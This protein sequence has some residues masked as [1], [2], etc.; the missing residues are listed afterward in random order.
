M[1]LKLSD[2][3]TE[4]LRSKIID[5]LLAVAPDIEDGKIDD[6]SP[7]QEIYGLDSAD[8][9]NFLVRIHNLFGIDIPAKDYGSFGTIEGAVE[10]I[11]AFLTTE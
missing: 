5:A 7:L 9:M 3:I 2:N 10:Y 1:R 11:R 6:S 8:F 4:T